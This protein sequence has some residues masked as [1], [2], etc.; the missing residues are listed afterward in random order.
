MTAARRLPREAD[1]AVRATLDAFRRIVQALRLAGRDVEGR[2]G[3]SSAQLFTLQQI[4]DH[5]GASINELAALTHTHQSSVSVVVRR[6]TER[7][8]AVKVK[9]SDDRRQHRLALTA[10]GERAIRRAP[11]PLQE[12]LIGAIGALPAADRRILAKAL[13]EV[14]RRVAP[15]GAAP[16]PMLFE[17]DAGKRLAKVRTPG[18]RAPRSAGR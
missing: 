10:R 12:R 13:G 14:A 17:E 16:P 7:R 9:S 18:A 1:T 4:A 6:L 8:L 2:V 3:L 5:P 15:E 11:E